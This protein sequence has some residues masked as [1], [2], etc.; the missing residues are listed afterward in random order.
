M[1]VLA[2]HC[3]AAAVVAAFAA[4]AHAANTAQ[5]SKQGGK[6][7]ISIKQSKLKWQDAPSIGPGAKIAILEGDPKGSGPFTMRIKAPANTKIGVHTHPTDERVTVLDGTLYFATGNKFDRRKAEAYNRG[8]GFVVPQGVPMYAY[9]GGKPATVQLNG[10]GPWGISY[11][12]AK[13]DPM[14]SATR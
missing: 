10:L 5:D 2:T 14:K 4:A 13:D 7:F 3:V 12:D 8:D 1:K 6:D 11:M 9:T